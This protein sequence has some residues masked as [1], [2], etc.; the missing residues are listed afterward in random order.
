MHRAY[1]R[2]HCSLLPILRLQ[3]YESIRTRNY[4]YIVLELVEN[5]SL[6]AALKRFGNFS[7]RLAG[8]CW[9][10]DILP[11]GIFYRQWYAVAAAHTLSFIYAALP[12]R[13]A[14]IYTSQ[15]LRGLCY[16]G[17]QGVIH[18]DLKGGNVLVDKKGTIKLADFGVAILHNSSAAPV[19]GAVPSAAAAP[20][21]TTTTTTTATGVSGS[22]RGRGKQRGKGR[23]GASAAPHPAPA[24]GGLDVAGR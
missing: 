8:D 16:L 7:E 13:V 5:G 19:S 6:S 2:G 3:Y 14:A 23:A 17:E 21:A 18:R 9:N 12:L 4:F 24:P 15:M 22:G 1:D 10:T 20:S 11:T